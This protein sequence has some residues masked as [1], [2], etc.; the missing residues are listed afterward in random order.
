MITAIPRGSFDAYAAL[1]FDCD[2]TLVDTMPAHYIAWRKTMQR[3]GIDFAED[4]FYSLGGVPAPTIVKMLSDEAGL[5]LDAQQIAHEKEE[6]YAHSL[7]AAEP[8][9][10]V[11]EI[12]ERYRG[13]LP[14]AVATGSHRWIAHHAL[15]LIGIRDWFD[16]IVT[17]EDVTHPKPA[18]DTYIEAAK[19]L[20]IAPAECLA[21]E[22]ADPG[23][24]SARDAGMDVIDVRPFYRRQA[25]SG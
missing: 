1:V 12:A 22:D 6:L 8:V 10:A 5:S 4:R 9:H 3:F 24:Q 16:C 15:D 18:P 21:F 2:G 23:I 25:A 17:F 13:K 19:Q 11:L 20:N 14:L 7:T